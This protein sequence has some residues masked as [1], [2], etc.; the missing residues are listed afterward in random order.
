MDGIAPE[1]GAGLLRPDGS[2]GA[3][4]IDLSQPLSP[5]M[6][7]WR[8]NDRAVVEFEEVPIDH[9]VVGGRISATRLSMVAHAGTHV[10]APRHF[11]PDGKSID[12]FGAD[13]FVCRGVALDVPLAGGEALTEDALRALDPGIGRGDAVLLHFGFADRYTTDDYHHHPYLSEGA[14][15]YLA[16]LEIGVLGVDVITPDRPSHLRGPRFEFP[17]HVAL[18]SREVLIIENLGPGLKEVVGTTFLFVFAP[19]SIPGADA[20]PVV[21]LA[22]V[23]ARSAP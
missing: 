15:R 11:F 4:A 8:G 16:D 23:P 5:S 13:R 10:D 12:D 19:F 3:R 9:G 21:P 6:A 17:V 2:A 22:L 1:H 18:L 20:S 7:G 14:A